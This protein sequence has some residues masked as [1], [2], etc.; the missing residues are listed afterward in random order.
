MSKSATMNAVLFLALATP[1]AAHA[2]AINVIFIGDSITRGGYLHR[3]PPAAAIDW[4]SGH[5]SGV[6]FFSSNQGRSGHTTADA[7]STDLAL[8]EQ[9]ATALERE[10]VGR[11]VFSVMLGTNDSAISG[12]HGAPVSPDHYRA[13][14]AALIDRLLKDYRGCVIVLQRPLWYSPNTDNGA[15][16][17]TEGLDRLQSYFPVIDEL[18]TR[19]AR[20]HPKKVFL[21]D[22]LGFELFRE[23][24]LIYLKAEGGHLGTYYL[25]PS[26]A[27]AEKLGELWGGAIE[28]A[29]RD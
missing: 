8:I 24:Y 6:D 23:N 19:Y 28:R 14:L 25:H 10:H 20:T 27:G 26:I 17:L 12:P 9:A 21:G 7:L 5:V 1:G 11:L 3:P 18:V 22:T 2:G 16:Y 4:L 29:I 13:N 15:K